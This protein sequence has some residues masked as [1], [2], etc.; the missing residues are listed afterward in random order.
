MHYVQL[1]AIGYL[2]NLIGDIPEDLKKYC[3]NFMGAEQIIFIKNT[4]NLKDLCSDINNKWFK[5]LVECIKW[6]PSER[7]TADN[8]YIKVFS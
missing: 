2:I 5:I 8:I 7:I 6:I 4:G 3:P 1:Y